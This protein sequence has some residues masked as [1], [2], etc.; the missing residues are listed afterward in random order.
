MFITRLLF[1]PSGIE[2]LTP[3]WGR[4][5][6]GSTSTSHQPAPAQTAS[7]LLRGPL[8][9]W[10]WRRVVLAGRT[11]TGAL[12]P[13]WTPLV[14]GPLIRTWPLITGRIKAESTSLSF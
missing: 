8:L 1:I 5:S 14:G 3:H 12:G 13:S 4:G 6:R 2:L 7:E 11:A 10:S 9:G